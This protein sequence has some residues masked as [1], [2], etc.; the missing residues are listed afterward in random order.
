MA[1]RNEIKMELAASVFAVRTASMQP[2]PAPEMR[3]G[4]ALGTLNFSA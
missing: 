2:T 4:A 1:T 3:D